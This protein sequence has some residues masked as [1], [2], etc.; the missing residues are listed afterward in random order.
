MMPSPPSAIDA[1]IAASAS[2]MWRRSSS[3]RRRAARRAAWHSMPSRTSQIIG[4][5]T[6][7]LATSSASEPITSPG[8]VTR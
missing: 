2:A 1:L 3:E 8:G 7:L 4:W 5:S 6:S